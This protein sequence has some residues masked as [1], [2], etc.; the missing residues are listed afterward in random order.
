M[1]DIYSWRCVYPT[2]ICWWLTI[3]WKVIMLI[4]D[5][6]LTKETY[7]LNYGCHFIYNK[8]GLKNKINK[9]HIHRINII[10]EIEVCIRVSIVDVAMDSLYLGY[11]YNSIFYSF[12][13]DTCI[14][15][16]IKTIMCCK[17]VCWF[18][19]LKKN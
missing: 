16:M 7:L 1:Y 3:L 8:G 14:I 18:L 12:G 4:N 5:T 2:C 11:I 9:Y 15:N 6:K 19:I 17:F 10:K 13:Y